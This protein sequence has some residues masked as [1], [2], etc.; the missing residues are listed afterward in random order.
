MKRE[1]VKSYFRDHC[2]ELFQSGE[3]VDLND[4]KQKVVVESVPLEITEIIS[5]DLNLMCVKVISNAGQW[6]SVG[7]NNE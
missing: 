7:V 5:A 6:L 2:L 3:S 1:S 4:V